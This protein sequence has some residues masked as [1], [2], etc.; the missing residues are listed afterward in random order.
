MKRISRNAVVENARKSFERER[1][2]GS[3]WQNNVLFNQDA[4]LPGKFKFVVDQIFNELKVSGYKPDQKR[5]D[6]EILLAN[7]LN[8][9]RRKPVSISM[10][11]NDYVKNRYGRASAFVIEVVKQLKELKMI[12][13]KSGFKTKKES[14]RTR[15]CATKKLLDYCPV[16]RIGVILNPKELVILRD[17]KGK[18]KGYK[19]TIETR[20]IRKILKRANEVNKQA[21]IRYSDTKIFAVLQSIFKEKFTWYG[22]LHTRGF[23]H[24]QGFSI[25]EREELTIN[26]DRIIEL[27]YKAL[28][29][30]LLY[31]S[32]GIQ[33][34]SDPYSV[35]DEREEAR[36]FLKHL[37]LAMINSKDII[38]A[39][40]AANYWLFKNHSEREQLNVIGISKAR[41]FILKFIKAHKPISHYFFQG[42]DTGMRVMNKDAKI[43]LDVV[44]HFIRQEIP[45]I[46]VHDSF[47]IQKQYGNELEQIMQKTYKKHTGGFEIKISSNLH[48]K[49]EIY[50]RV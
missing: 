14:R 26:G 37:L 38:Q 29:P 16:S 13:V 23:R 12:E 5:K 31:A 30:N 39:E 48:D 4:G 19:D 28:H 6:V 27:D 10:N 7:L 21:D 45:I 46:P 40:R 44:N 17:E 49:E 9:R 22:R 35:V 34:H 47:I 25:S 3:F 24:P 15:I 43:A 32:E 36:R 8:N 18:L 50:F 42:K 2:S 20:R 1:E 11:G 33:Y 41:P